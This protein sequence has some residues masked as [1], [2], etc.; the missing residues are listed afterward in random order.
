M[1][2][3]LIRLMSEQKEMTPIR[4]RFVMCDSGFPSSGSLGEGTAGLLATGC[5]G[6]HRCFQQCCLNDCGDTVIK[7]VCQHSKV[8]GKEHHE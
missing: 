2:G 7:S 1:T 3:R 6:S 4:I 5:C 8:M